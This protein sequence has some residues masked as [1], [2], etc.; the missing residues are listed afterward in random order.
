MEK[1]VDALC[2]R[3]A[4]SFHAFCMLAFRPA[5]SVYCRGVNKDVGVKNVY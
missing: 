4:L 5:V 3:I 1:G 2:L